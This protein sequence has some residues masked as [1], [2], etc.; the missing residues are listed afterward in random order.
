MTMKNDKDKDMIVR[1]S[2]ASRL[3]HWLYVIPFVILLITGSALVFHS[4]SVLVG[5]EGLKAFGKIHIICGAFLTVVPVTILVLF[6]FNNFARWIKDISTFT[7]DDKR[8]V[9]SFPKSLFNGR[10]RHDIPQGRFNGGEKINSWLQIVGFLTLVA[11]G[12]IMF[13]ADSF[14]HDT[15]L[16]AKAIHGGCA[17]LLG[18]IVLGHAFLGLIHPDSRESMR[19]II[20]GVVSRKY[21]KNHHPLWLKEVEHNEFIHN[22]QE[23]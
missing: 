11:T 7:N 1:F 5:N 23:K 3:A 2:L 8:F 12:W 4:F 19:G 14:S 17:L 18:A 10:Y 13:F 6:S 20:F 21:A 9:A 22:R 15:F 16:M